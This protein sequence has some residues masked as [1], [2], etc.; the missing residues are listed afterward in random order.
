MRIADL[1]ISHLAPAD[2]DLVLNP[3]TPGVSMC[4]E[5]GALV[6]LPDIGDVDERLAEGYSQQFVDLLKI[7]I[8]QNY[9]H[10]RFESIGSIVDGLP[11]FDED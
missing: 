3:D 8:R 11:T 6:Y 5:T 7:A 1:S 10:I 9:T 2:R 4:G